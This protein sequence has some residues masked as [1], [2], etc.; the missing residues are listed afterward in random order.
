MLAAT[1][2]AAVRSMRRAFSTGPVRALMDGAERYPIDAQPRRTLHPASTQRVDAVVCD[3][4]ERQALVCARSLGHAGLAVGLLEGRSDVPAFH[5]RW[6]SSRG[7]VPDRG[8]RAKE[9]VDAVL[10]SAT[11]QQAR[12]LFPLHDGS[13]DAIRARRDEVERHVAL[14]LASETALDVAVTKART[15]AVASELGICIPRSVEVRDM[16]DVRAAASEL[17]F[18]MIV[19]PSTSWVQGRRNGRRLACT[20][21]VNLGEALEAV[22]ALVRVGGAPI[23]QEW[24]VGSREAVSLF[25]AERR[26]WGRF[27]QIAHRMY[28]PVGGSSVVRESIPLPADLADAAELLVE[29]C[30]L[31]G[32]SEIEFRR[33]AHG[34]ARLMEINPRLSASVEIAVRAGVDFPLLLYRWAAGEKLRA[35]PGFRTG[36]RQRWLGGDV[37]WL[38]KTLTSQGRPEA[39]PALQAIGSFCADFFRPASYDYL[40]A[41]DVSPAF[42]AAA[43]WAARA[44]GAATNRHNGGG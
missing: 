20:L 29:A 11:R 4:A 16:T 21:V 8:T 12:V 33:D 22:D 42:V 13:I 7:I 32:Y 27:A 18:P 1:P 41:R 24:L 5:S 38:R 26:V 39:E 17:G 36:I 6:C 19:K 23:L 31:D 37:M 14:P 10:E 35:V 3:A 28:P 9:F 43:S 30:D 40:D 44:V 34:R 25:R 15:L 2:L